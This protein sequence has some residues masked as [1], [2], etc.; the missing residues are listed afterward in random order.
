MTLAQI[1]DEIRSLRPS[2]RIELY[3]WLDYGVVADY[4]VET[5]FCS[6]I[7]MDRSLEIRARIRPEG[8][9][10]RQEHPDERSRILEGA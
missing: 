7:G 6:R 9:D 3:R 8:E 5:D 1:E 4:G 10:Q 2:E